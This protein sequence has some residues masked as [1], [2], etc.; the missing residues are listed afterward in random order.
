[1]IERIDTVHPDEPSMEISDAL[2]QTIEKINEIINKLN[3]DEKIKEANEMIEKNVC[4][5]IITK[6]DNVY[7]VGDMVKCII[8]EFP[9]SGYGKGK[10]V[11]VYGDRSYSIEFD[12]GYEGLLFNN[13]IKLI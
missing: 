4:T 10:I 3:I 7:K 12:N 6:N 1:M 2:N 8:S 13:E 11:E 5:P 9:A